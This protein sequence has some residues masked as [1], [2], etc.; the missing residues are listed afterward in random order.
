MKQ[1]FHPKCIFE[2][3]AKAKSTT[4]IIESAEDV[5]NWADLEQSDK[6]DMLKL[7]KGLK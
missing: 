7:I 3:F 1:Y 2:T 4:K 5:E 6:D